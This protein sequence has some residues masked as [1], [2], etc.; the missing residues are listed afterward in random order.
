MVALSNNRDSSGFDR[1]EQN[2]TDHNYDILLFFCP[3]ARCLVSRL[4]IVLVVEISA[5]SG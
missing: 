5:G 4:H 2:P 3:N 1:I